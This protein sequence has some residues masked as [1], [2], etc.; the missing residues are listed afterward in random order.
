MTHGDRP[1][2]GSPGSTPEIARAKPFGPLDNVWAMSTWA[3][4]SLRWA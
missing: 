2:S 3:P 1:S 4:I